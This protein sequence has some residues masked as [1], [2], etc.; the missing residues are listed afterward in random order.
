MEIGRKVKVDFA[1]IKRWMIFILSCLVYLG[2]L[3][4]G[5]NINALIDCFSACAIRKMK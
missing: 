2:F 5:R 3:I 1:K 4:F